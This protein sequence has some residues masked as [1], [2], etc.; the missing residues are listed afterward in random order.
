MADNSTIYLEADEIDHLTIR[1]T[2]FNEA[3]NRREGIKKIRFYNSKYQNVAMVLEDV[4]IDSLSV[5][6]TDDE[7]VY[8]LLVRVRTALLGDVLEG[9]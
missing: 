3:L 6:N 4:D 1:Y 9:I 7:A 8:R 5:E 2:D